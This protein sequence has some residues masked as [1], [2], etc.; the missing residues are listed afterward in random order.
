MLALIV[1]LLAAG[2]PLP[3]LHDAYDA[4][5][6]QGRAA[7]KPVVVDLWAP[8]CHTC[9]SMQQTVLAD[10]ALADVADAFV[11]VAL[12]TDKP[13]NFPAV[14]RLKPG[15]WP[16]FYIVDATSQAVLARQVG[17]ASPAEWRAFLAAGRQAAPAE[18]GLRA[19]E[20][21]AAAGKLDEAAG[22]YAAALAQAGPTWPRRA[23]ALTDWL[24]TLYHL[25]RYDECA[26]GALARLAEAASGTS[27]AADFT[28]YALECAGQAREANLGARLRIAL[29]APDAPLTRLLAAPSALTVD[30]HS[31]ALRIRRELLDALG[32]ADGAKKVAQQQY[33]LLVDAWDRSV[34]RARMAYGWPLAE[35]SVYLGR[36]ADILPRLQQTAKDLPTEYDPPYRLAWVLQQVGQRYA[37]LAAARQA[38]GLAYGPRKGRVLALAA[39]IIQ[40]GGDV[41]ASRAAWEA[42]LAWQATLPEN[43]RLASLDSQARK[44]LESLTK[45]K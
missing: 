2:G 32:D 33:A 35:V 22:L 44:A 21:A 7:S 28:A 18:Q 31:D 10:P 43:V 42:V 37:A 24:G 29:A 30:D 12:D 19:A 38:E 13:V 16:T 36:G 27:A 23:A 11:W 14:E 5:L 20:A 25:E 40:A 3:W 1:T 4:A 45:V 26:H 15:A 9:L 41:A 17:S 8:W 39:T 34:P 6:E